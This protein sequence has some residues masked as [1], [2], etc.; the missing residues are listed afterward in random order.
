MKQQCSSTG[1]DSSSLL[2]MV[3]CLFS[4]LDTWYSFQHH[5]VCTVFATKSPSLLS[6]SKACT[7]DCIG[8]SF[9]HPNKRISPS[10]YQLAAVD[11]SFL[12]RDVLVWI[13]CKEGMD[14]FSRPW[15]FSFLL[16]TYQGKRRGFADYYGILFSLFPD[17][18]L[19]LFSCSTSHV[20]LHFQTKFTCNIWS[21]MI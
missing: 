2:S 20:W 16:Q 5:F 13:F 15:S 19:K 10:T 17:K 18:K 9:F 6:C 11:N 1:T 3:D 8:I 14:V 12:W 21:F 7:L 4:C